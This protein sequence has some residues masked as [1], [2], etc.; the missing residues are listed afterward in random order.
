MRNYCVY[1]PKF[2]CVR[3]VTLSHFTDLLMSALIEDSYILLSVSIFI[4]LRRDTSASGKLQ[5]T[6][7]RQF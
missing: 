2:V 6:L 1:P 3:R 7:V 5:C 4:L